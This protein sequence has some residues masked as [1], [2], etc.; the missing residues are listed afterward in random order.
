M[1]KRLLISL[2]V[3]IAAAASSAAATKYQFTYY[4]KERGLPRTVAQDI[5]QDS[6][7]CLWLAT[8]SG[9]YR[10]DG[11]SFI[12]FKAGRADGHGERTNNRFDRI[13]RDGFGQFWVLSYDGTL[14]RFD[15]QRERFSDIANGRNI[16]EIYRLSSDDFCFVTSDNT[17]L[18]TRY[19]DAGH[20]CILYDSSIAAPGKVN[21]MYKDNGDNIWTATDA[22]I[23][24]NNE[25]ATEQPG[26][27]IAGSAGAIRFGSGNGKIVEVI[28]GQ[29]FEIESGAPYDIRLITD[30]PGTHELILGS[31]DGRL[32]MLAT[33]KM[34]LKAITVPES[35]SIGPEPR[36]FYDRK[37][38]VWIWS[39]LGGIGHLDRET[40][41]LEP[42]I[43]EAREPGGWDAENNIQ[44]AFLDKQDNIWFSGSWGG[45]GRASRKDSGFKLLSFDKSGSAPSQA[46]S[47]RAVTQ[48]RDGMIYAGTKDGKIHLLSNNLIH[49]A[50]WSLPYPAY[51]ITEDG[52]GH[53]W[54]GTK[55]GGV[56]ENTAPD[57]ALKPVF[58]PKA[59][60]KSDARFGMN[61]DLIYCLTPGSNRRLWIGSFDGSISYVDTAD[62]ER[63]FISN[64]NRIPFPT[65]QMDKIRFITFGPDGRMFA[66]GRK[67][68]FICETP[69]SDPELM[70]FERF[71][72]TREYDI[73]HILFGKDGK[74]YASS[75]GNGLL[76][77]SPDDA[78]KPETINADNGLMSNFVFSSI[79]D[80]NGNIWISTYHGLNKYN[81]K[82]GKIIGWSYD[83][84]GKDLL[85]AEG[86]PLVT[87]DGEMMFN[88]TAGILYFKPEEISN[89]SFAP[90]VFLTY[91][92]FAGNRI[93]PENGRTIEIRGEGRL[94]IR[95]AAVDMNGPE[96]VM[97]SWRAG[98]GG[99]WTQLGNTPVLNLD[100]LGTGRHE[101]QLRA[102]NADGVQMDNTLDITVIVRPD[103]YGHLKMAILLVIIALSAAAYLL[104]RK[105]KAREAIRQNEGSRDGAPEPAR[106][107]W[108]DTISEE[109][110]KFKRRFQDFLEENL[111]N[112][113][114]GA[115]DMAEA[116][117][118]SRSALFEKCRA[119]LGKAPTEYLRDLR[120]SRAAEMM[121]KSGYSISQIAY[122]T[123]FNDSHYFSKAFKK[124][125]GVSPTE[126]RK[127]IK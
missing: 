101:L 86:E 9:L 35:C 121:A 74:M 25:I 38:T 50:D 126:Y 26:Y 52:Q 28:D 51:S 85:F 125:F 103:I 39:P 95:F 67:G 84:I 99:E 98:S 57:M 127:S 32:S 19:S 96:R 8:W 120:F 123:G 81:P 90:K 108:D 106:P 117:G 124:R 12:G 42:L 64:K 60:K 7:G 107:D 1:I 94:S 61:G 22:A 63:R 21:G 15:P 13:E 109:D 2:F 102:T 24:C 55:G 4:L 11:T 49:I 44:A 83:R 93:Y 88:T 70:R 75:F 40:L 72:S 91:C 3:I 78:I 48:T 33:D 46:N 116:L 104:I 71:A 80:E 54:I 30:V 122:K 65:S 66:C 53:I 62:P 45:I 73:Q 97:Y 110:S 89:S 87:K 68:T 43:Y 58:R 56:F 76:L 119:L 41:R 69:D 105:R 114:L 82:T 36:S 47:V 10:F 14:Y 100:G 17:I 31:E 115:E 112:G 92:Q 6:N 16:T 34:E 111:D 23:L 118:V 77:C 29:L 79:E 5:T 113:D 27:C 18:R 59:Y 20:S 37:G